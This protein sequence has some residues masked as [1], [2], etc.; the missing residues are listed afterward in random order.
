MS[1]I[2]F[3]HKKA[4]VMIRHKFLR[5][6]QIIAVVLVLSKVTILCGAEH[7][8]LKAFPPANEGMERFVI[9]LPEKERGQDEGFK[10]E[11]IPGKSMPS[12]GVNL[13]RLGISIKPHPLTGW[14]YTY[15]EVSGRDV[16][17]ST[18]MAVPEG[19]QQV[20]A[21]VAGTS[22]LI[23]YNSRL[24]IIVYAPKGFEIRYRIWNASETTKSAEKG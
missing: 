13:M 10:V 5:L 11:L 23:R 6:W 15:Y 19:T 20:E 17:M 8:E 24:P 16:A 14:G 3:I 2:I 7:P 21:F 9:V 4:E 22:L 18:M 12:D 1:R